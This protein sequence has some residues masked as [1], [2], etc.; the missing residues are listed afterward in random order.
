MTGKLTNKEFLNALFHEEPAKQQ[1]KLAKM[2][3]KIDTDKDG[4]VEFS[5][6]IHLA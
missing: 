6:F 5:E 4:G 1:Q 2:L 3:T